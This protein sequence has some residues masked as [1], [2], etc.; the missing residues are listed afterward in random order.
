MAH[1]HVLPLAYWGRRQASV[2]TDSCGAELS[3][4]DAALTLHNP[5]SPPCCHASFF[6]FYFSREA[7]TLT[8]HIATIYTVRKY[9]PEG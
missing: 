3:K 8:E 1:R 7:L 5:V 2:G 9:G 6:Y 4:Q